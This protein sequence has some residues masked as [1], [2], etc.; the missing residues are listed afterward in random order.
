MNHDNAGIEKAD[1]MKKWKKIFAEAETVYIYGAAR[2][3]KWLYEFAKETVA[4]EKIKG[5]LV[6]DTT[7]NPQMLC[8]LPVCGVRSAVDRDATILVPQ[9]GIY[10]PNHTRAWKALGY[11][12][13]GRHSIEYVN[14]V[15]EN[16]FILTCVFWI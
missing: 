3:G 14:M 11:R 9:N 16:C 12:G 6:T 8:G 5:F 15:C 2:G 13:Q 10:K 1:L 4:H 7:K